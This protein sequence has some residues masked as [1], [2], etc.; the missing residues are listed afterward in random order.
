MQH[1]NH[2]IYFWQNK[3]AFSVPAQIFYRNKILL[4]FPSQFLWFCW[5]DYFISLSSSLSHASHKLNIHRC[6][7]EIGRKTK[8][9]SLTLYNGQEKYLGLS[10]LN[11]ERESCSAFF[12][13][14]RDRVSTIVNYSTVAQ[15]RKFYL[16]FKWNLSCCTSRPLFLVLDSVTWKIGYCLPLPRLSTQMPASRSSRG[17]LPEERCVFKT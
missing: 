17:K 7:I 11:W 8:I 9:A 6:I 1:P 10:A 12:L 5:W 15:I 2:N 4:P 16:M 13:T 3:T 14:S